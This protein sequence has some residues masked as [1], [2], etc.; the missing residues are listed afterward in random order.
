MNLSIIIL[1]FHILRSGR[2]FQ[3]LH[4][5]K[6]TRKVFALVVGF[7]EASFLHILGQSKGAPYFAAF[8]S[9]KKKWEVVQ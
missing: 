3:S 1:L 6:V 4:D 2:G 8:L 9:P 7:E 5:L